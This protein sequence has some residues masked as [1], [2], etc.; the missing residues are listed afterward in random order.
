MRKSE[1]P[2]ETLSPWIARMLVPFSRSPI[3]AETSKLSMFAG[4]SWLAVGAVVPSGGGLGVLGPERAAV[5]VGDEPVV[6]AHPQSE[7]L[8]QRGVRHRKRDAHVDAGVDVLEFAL[9]VDRVVGGIVRSAHL[10]ANAVAGPGVPAVGVEADPGPGECERAVAWYEDVGIA[11]GDQ[12]AG[13]PAAREG[14][15]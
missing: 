9:D 8:D 11:S 7:R 4:A 5:E 10:I 3:E 2:M 12:V 13:R 1:L 15:V 6:E 14:A